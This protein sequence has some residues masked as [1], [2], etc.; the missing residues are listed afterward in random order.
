[1]KLKPLSVAIVVSNRKNAV[2]WYQKKL[3]LD[4]IDR[5]GH[6]VTVGSKRRG[7]RLHLC[8]TTEF[9]PKGK[10]EPGNSGIMFQVDG[11]IEKAYR[12]LKRRGVKFSHPPKKMEW[13]WYCGFLDPDGNEFWMVPAD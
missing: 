2:R 10:L 3:G 7:I 1:M 6:W 13:G 9:D 8:Q 11:D 4:V 12:A 5:E